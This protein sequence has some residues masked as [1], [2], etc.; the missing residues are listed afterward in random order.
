MGETQDNKA[1]LTESEFCQIVGISRTT[2]WR[3]RE[4]GKL[5]YCQVGDKILYLPKHIDEFLASVEKPA[6]A[7]NRQ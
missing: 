1:T 7:G 4:A 2:A 5:S 3:M 6:R